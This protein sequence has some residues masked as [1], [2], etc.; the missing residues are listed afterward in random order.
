MNSYHPADSWNEDTEGTLSL[1]WNHSKEWPSPRRAPGP[2]ACPPLC[3]VTRFI[4]QCWMWKFYRHADYVSNSTVLSSAHFNGTTNNFICR[5]KYKQ[6]DLKLICNITRRQLCNDLR[7]SD[8]WGFALPLWSLQLEESLRR[9]WPNPVCSPASR[10]LLPHRTHP[11]EQ[12][13]TVKVRSS[14][15][16]YV[17]SPNIFPEKIEAVAFQE[18]LSVRT[19]IHAW[20]T[21]RFTAHHYNG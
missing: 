4:I 1:S 16:S 14:V 12:C 15:V 20:D 5:E 19:K 6:T 10:A 21:V 8:L 3:K 7:L 9:P 13:P 17:H 11:Q 18:N 2:T